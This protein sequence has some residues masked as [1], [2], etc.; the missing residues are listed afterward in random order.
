VNVTT[1]PDIARPRGGS[2]RKPPTQRIGVGTADV[3]RARASAVQTLAARRL[4]LADEL[5]ES[6]REAAPLADLLALGEVGPPDPDIVDEA[7]VSSAAQRPDVL[8]KPT[9]IVEHL[10]VVYRVLVTGKRTE[11]KGNRKLEREAASRGIREIHAV[12][13]ISFV[14]HEGEAIGLIGVNGSG[15]STL[16]RAIAGLQPSAGGR[17]WAE[18]DPTLLGVNATLFGELSGERNILIGGLAM[19][20]SPTEIAKRAPAIADFA[21]IGEFI[22]LPMMTYSSGMG[23][24]LRFAIASATV[25]RILLIDEALATGD[26]AFQRRSEARI[27]ELR[28]TAGTV[29]VVSHSDGVIRSTCSRTIWMHKGEMIMDGLT[30]EVLE[31][32]DA[33]SRGRR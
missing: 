22:D 10:H 1:A 24:R 3:A 16:L 25:Y 2:R 18:A 4:R 6:E 33:F 23:S 32:Y 14:A 31:C 9:I 30:D 27:N 15:K 28:E 11:N 8:G 12:N 26:S 19:G 20:M 7:V 17:V 5:A 29:F 21:A 13:D